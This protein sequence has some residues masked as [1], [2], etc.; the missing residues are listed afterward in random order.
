[1]AAA[2]S[3]LLERWVLHLFRCPRFTRCDT[4]DSIFPGASSQAWPCCTNL[5]AAPALARWELVRNRELGRASLE[6]P[7]G[8]E[9][10]AVSGRSLPEPICW[11]QRWWP[12]H[13][14]VGGWSFRTG[15]CHLLR[16]C[17]IHEDPL[18][19]TVSILWRT[20]LVPPSCLPRAFLVPNARSRSPRSA[21]HTPARQ[22]LP[23]RQLILPTSE[24]GRDRIAQIARVRARG[25]PRDVRTD[26]M[27]YS[28][29]D[30]EVSRGQH[31]GLDAQEERENP[32]ARDELA[33]RVTCENLD[34]ALVEDDD[35]ALTSEGNSVSSGD[36]V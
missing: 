19:L 3:P 18:N 27:W 7:P 28:K 4:A 14:G 17:D 36:A 6:G 1:M 20:H 5:N 24:G 26:D 31:G 11:G 35:V 12:R 32:D 13:A 15:P 33:E 21:N 2:A 8:E 23:V 10:E 22:A 29:F 9:L 30:V 25:A 34:H 16:L